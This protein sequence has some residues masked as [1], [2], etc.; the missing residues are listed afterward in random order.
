MKISCFCVGGVLFL[1]LV[2]ILCLCCHP[3]RGQEYDALKFFKSTLMVELN[4][5]EDS[6]KYRSNATNVSKASS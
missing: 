6:E 3:D 4:E 2:V 5:E 1:V